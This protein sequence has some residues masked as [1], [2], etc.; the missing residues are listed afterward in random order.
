MSAAGLPLEFVAATIPIGVIADMARTATNV[1]AAAVSAT[2]VA[3]QTGLLDDEIFAG[4]AE[5][6]DEDDPSRRARRHRSPRCP[7]PPYATAV[8]EPRAGGRPMK[9]RIVARRCRAW[10]S[11]CSRCPAAAHAQGVTNPAEH[12]A[13]ITVTIDGQTY[14]DGLDTLPGYD[15]E[16]CTPIPNVQYDFADNQIQYYDSD[17][18]LI[19]TAHWTE[20]ARIS[21]YDD[22]EGAAAG[23]D[24]D[25]APPTPTAATATT[26]AS[27]DARRPSSTTRPRRAPPRRAPA[28]DEPVDHQH[29]DDHEHDHQELDDQELRRPRARR[30]RARRPRAP[31]RA[32]RPRRAPPPTSPSSPSTT[33]STSTQTTSSSAATHERRGTS[34]AAAPRRT[35]PRPRP[36]RRPTATPAD[37]AATTTVRRDERAR[38]RRAATPRRGAGAA[39]DAERSEPTT[40]FK[41][42]SQHLGAAG[43]AADTRL[44]GVGI[45]AALFGVAGL[46]LVFRGF[47]RRQVRPRGS[48]R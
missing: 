37:A 29:H 6:V 22:L 14:H 10:A 39:V 34:T 5:F 48:R 26:P 7:F 16:A 15:D 46:G 20:W 8:A 23:A 41:L 27:R 47:A 19:K 18:E 9:R 31:R 38:R 11:P 24:A 42:A 32:A 4:R 33:S 17:G 36:P 35:T 21:S 25:A 3:R 43:G 1:T 40:K 28:D 2:V 12:P 13:P 44:A 30:P 45:L